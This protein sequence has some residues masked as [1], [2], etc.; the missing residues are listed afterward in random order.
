MVLLLLGGLSIVAHAQTVEPRDLL[1]VVD[2]GSPIVSPDGKQVAFRIE[3]ASVER[4]TYDT[5][6]YVQDVDGSSLPHRIAEG[7]GVLRDSAGLPLPANAVWSPDGRWIY[8]RALVDDRIAMWRASVNG[9]GASPITGD[10]ADVREFALVDDGRTLKYSVG[11]SREA[12]LE[13][14]Q[15]EYDR[16]IRIDSSVP[17]GQSLFRSGNL[18]GRLAT[19]RYGKIWFDRVSLLADV[20][21]RWKALD[22]QTAEV[23]SLGAGDARGDAEPGK[24][25]PNAWLLARSPEDD[26]LAI[27]TRIGEK[28][29]LRYKPDVKL[30]AMLPRAGMREIACVA[31]LCTGKAITAIQ[32]RPHSDEVLF[33]V[34]DSNAGGAQSLYRWNARSGVVLPVAQSSG[35]LNGGRDTSS[36]CGVSRTAMVCVSATA[37]QPPRLERIDLETGARQILY[38]PNAA[39]AQAMTRSSSVRLLRWTDEKGRVFTGQFYA[40]QRDDADPAP[41]LFVNYYRCA[42]FVRGGVGDEYPFASLAAHGVAALC[43]NAAPYVVDAV[44][45]YDDGLAA[46]ESAVKALSV[47]GEIDC[48]RVGMGGLSFGSEVAVWTLMKSKLLAAA[49]VSSVSVSPSFY[50]L[51]SL[52][53]KG[54]RDGLKELWGL[55]APEETPARWRI[56]SPAFNLDRISAPLLLQVPEQEYLQAIDYVFP[57]I[58]QD[59]ADLYVFPNEP[60][61]KFQPR[62]KLAVYLRNL[63]WFR[64]WL[65]SFEDADSFKAAQYAHWRVLRERAEQ[66]QSLRPGVC[67]KPAGDQS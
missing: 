39:L 27:L 49:S 48:T 22:V 50:L 26:R 44:E 59:M 7:G 65:Q 63:D 28:N 53:G 23:R 33:T 57:L 12:V 18:E 14:E 66:E 67:K 32:W 5:F 41:P 16:G 43:I 35:L 31:V 38:E 2:F 58:G 45:R 60:H 56:L 8:Y 54:F 15:A 11:P 55:G 37:A 42:G 30:S 64:F 25:Y 19:Q 10:S 24:Q 21:D 29:G 9:S 46:V 17:V 62:H 13:A 52:K 3:Q 20:P 34:T 40:A 6:W 61:Q 51:G 4:N 1:E 47:T 36:N